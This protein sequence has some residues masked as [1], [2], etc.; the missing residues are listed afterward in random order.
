ML[1]FRFRMTGNV[2]VVPDPLTNSCFE[3]HL[4]S[5]INRKD[6]QLI[7]NLLTIPKQKTI[8]IITRENDAICPV[9]GNQQVSIQPN[10]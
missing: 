7:Q 4:V 1:G 10:T 5:T 8:E 6:V 2:F 9:R 3:Q